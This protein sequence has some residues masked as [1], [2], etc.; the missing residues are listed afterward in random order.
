MVL[1]YA[2]IAV[3]VGVITSEVIA[4][5]QAREEILSGEESG[6]LEYKASAYYSHDHPIPEDTLFRHAVRRTVA[7]FL[8][9]RGGRL[10]IGVNDDGDVLGIER[11]LEY[12]AWDC[13]RYVNTITQRIGSDL[14]L[15]AAAMTT[16]T[17]EKFPRGTVCNVEVLPSSNPVFVKTSNN[18]FAFYVRVNNTTQEL[19]GNDLANY[20]KRRWD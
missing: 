8:N 19:K 14:G 18:Q 7:G 13:D 1:G 5:R 12:K 20:I 11:D 17:M 3:P 6:R 10:V 16:I 2:L 4:S 9:A 15:D